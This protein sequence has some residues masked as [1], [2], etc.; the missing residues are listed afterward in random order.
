MF[1]RR[2]EEARRS[3]KVRRASRRDSGDAASRVS[4]QKSRG[5][6]AGRV[7]WTH[8]ITLITAI[9]GATVS[10]VASSGGCI[11]TSSTAVK[12]R[13]CFLSYIGTAVIQQR[14]ARFFRVIFQSNKVDYFSIIIIIFNLIIWLVHYT[15]T[16]LLLCFVI[17]SQNLQFERSRE[18]CRV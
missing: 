16:S 4:H 11:S 7:T 6:T 18:F 13:L 9:V 15:I 5:I 10:S 1:P 17:S 3:G 8:S 14:D 12:L 2:Y